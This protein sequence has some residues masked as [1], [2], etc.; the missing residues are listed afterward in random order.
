MQGASS[1][2]FVFVQGGSFVMGSEDG[3]ED[4][5]PAHKVTIDNFYICNHEVTQSEWLNVMKNNPSFYKGENRP[6]E[7]VSWYDA[8]EYCNLL[9]K[10]EC[11]KLRGIASSIRGHLYGSSMSL[12]IRVSSPSLSI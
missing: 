5:K 1:K 3:D 7:Q 4:E 12:Y 6:V 2:S 10:I 11:E 9:S 8:I